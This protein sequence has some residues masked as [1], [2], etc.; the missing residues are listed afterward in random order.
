MAIRTI[1]ICD[2]KNS[3]RTPNKAEYLWQGH[4]LASSIDTKI[5]TPSQVIN[6]LENRESLAIDKLP[7]ILFIHARDAEAKQI[8]E[9]ALEINN[10]IRSFHIML[11]TGGTRVDLPDWISEF[12]DVRL[13]YG[14]TWREQLRSEIADEKIREPSP[15][16]D[17]Y[18]W[19]EEQRP[20]SPISPEAIF[21]KVELDK[22][23]GLEI[24]VPYHPDAI[25][26][27][28]NDL[29]KLRLGIADHISKHNLNMNS[30]PVKVPILLMLEQTPEDPPIQKTLELFKEYCQLNS[31]ALLW[32]APG[33]EIFT[34]DEVSLLDGSCWKD[35]KVPQFNADNP[36]EYIP[37]ELRQRLLR[38]FFADG[39]H[40]IA[41][42]IAPHRL[43]ATAQACEY[44]PQKQYNAAIKHLEQTKRNK[45]SDLQLYIKVA[46]LTLPL[47]TG[48]GKIPALP[49]DLRVLMID[50]EWETQNWGK[51]IATMMNLPEIQFDRISVFGQ[52]Q[53]IDIAIFSHS[54][55]NSQLLCITPEAWKNR[56]NV[57]INV[58]QKLLDDFQPD[59]VL[60]D[61][62]ARA[63]TPH[64]DIKQ[65]E[66]YRILKDL[67]DYETSCCRC[68][69]PVILFSATNK[70]H[71]LA[72]LA[73]QGING[74]FCKRPPF[75]QGGIATEALWLEELIILLVKAYRYRSLHNL[76]KRFFH[77][78]P[79]INKNIT[80]LNI[81]NRITRRIY[82]TIS[83]MSDVYRRE[84]QGKN[85]SPFQNPVVMCHQI[86][87]DIQDELEYQ[88]L[89]PNAEES[90][91]LK[92]IE[93][94]WGRNEINIV[95]A[96]NRKRNDLIHNN[97]RALE[98]E[99]LAALD[100]AISL[101]AKDFSA[102]ND[103]TRKSL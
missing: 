17:C 87:Y 1:W 5:K 79:R 66:G 60:L 61:L 6:I 40:Q 90:H 22:L 29:F 71:S 21:S 97:E 73:Q 64:I 102:L 76:E 11:F 37:L 15:P 27:I 94:H 57:R 93:K 83:E 95:R 96:L 100:I 3:Q 32:L 65:T 85:Y 45:R 23:L 44:V 51:I 2:S 35:F 38:E 56:R 101:L 88:G 25:Q 53:E 58:L 13:L 86:L 67:R 89:I 47:P 43:L 28:C 30:L 77:V 18:A 39:E 7:D 20:S 75:L 82:Q 24:H 52:S 72:I 99:A 59:V 10:S 98:A 54:N 91:H 8:V 4:P 33:F 69:L 42:A 26:A 78:L 81:R 9:L 12:P 49:D 14:Q 68:S 34:Q 80:S 55:N 92:D 103:N 19:T 36:I 74:H 62:R 31:W 41:N 48:K 84:I 50:D 70:S 46:E 16:I 63:E